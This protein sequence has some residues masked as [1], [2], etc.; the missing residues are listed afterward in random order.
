MNKRRRKKTKPPRHRAY[1]CKQNT[2]NIKRWKNS[3]AICTK[4]KI[5][6]DS[7]K[8]MCINCTLSHCH[9]LCTKPNH[10]KLLHLRCA[11]ERYTQCENCNILIHVANGKLK[12]YLTKDIQ[13]QDLSKKKKTYSKTTKK[14]I[15]NSMKCKAS[16][17]ISSSPK[18]RDFEVRTSKVHVNSDRKKIQRRS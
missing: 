8:Y 9:P 10:F 2:C 18:A 4:I 12:K 3:S 11:R 15:S 17:P 16:H 6:W 13:K 1:D 7:F 14:K 5:R